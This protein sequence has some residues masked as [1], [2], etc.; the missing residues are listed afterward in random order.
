[1]RSLTPSHG[2][3]IR[4]QLIDIEWDAPGD[5]LQ[6]KQ[7]LEH[8]TRNQLLPKMEDLLDQVAGAAYWIR[9]DELV[10]D[11]GQLSYENWQAELLTKLRHELQSRLDD[12]RS[13]GDLNAAQSANKQSSEARSTSPNVLDQ[14]SEY[15]YSTES[16]NDQHTELRYKAAIF[17]LEYGR[18]P[19]WSARQE[20]VGIHQALQNFTQ[21]QWQ[22]TARLLE[23]SA[24]ALHRLVAICDDT[25]LDQCLASVYRLSNGAGSMAYFAPFAKT[26]RHY[27]LWR[28]YYWQTLFNIA[29]NPNATAAPAL[30]RTLLLIGLALRQ[31]IEQGATQSWLPAIDTQS[32]A[33]TISSHLVTE[34]PHPWRDWSTGLAGLGQPYR[35]LEPNLDRLFRRL[36]LGVDSAQLIGCGPSVSAADGRDAGASAPSLRQLPPSHVCSPSDVAKTS[37]IANIPQP[38]TLWGTGVVLAHPFLAELF[39]S[40]DLLEGT[41]FVDEAAR[42]TGVEL[43]TYLCFGEL[44]VEEYDLLLPKLLCQLPWQTPLVAIGLT[45]EQRQ[46]C[47]ELLLAMLKH[48][49]ALK[50]QS[51]DFLRQQF[52]WRRGSI[53]PVDQG[54]R[55]TIDRKAQDVLLDKLPW[56]VSVI[57]L[58]WMDDTLFTEW[59]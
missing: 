52:F 7:Q 55:L 26:H 30:L 34:L 54:W 57:R 8:F 10:I 39:G 22:A 48:W 12:H 50:T 16:A 19:S 51:T 5:S 11:L 58:P 28:I 20:A 53:K 40:L 41:R 25:V 43:I 56:G 1:M 45:E 29:A 21:R 23:R 9:F 33:R 6:L 42:H 59:G 46:G 3:R 36:L 14:E 35:V 38:L 49:A 32:G 13:S 4:R 44:A 47:D 27:R 15:P 17:F 24:D 31:A 18:L 2:H 37:S